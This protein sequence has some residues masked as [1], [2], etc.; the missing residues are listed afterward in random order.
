ME[1][2]SSINDRSWRSRRYDSSDEEE[3]EDRSRSYDSSDEAKEGLDKDEGKKEVDDKQ[4]SKK[5]IE[6]ARKKYLDEL[7]NKY[8]LFSSP[9]IKL[10][11]SDYIPYNVD[12]Y[13]KIFSDN[14][15]NIDPKS[16]MLAPIFK[17][18][19]LDLYEERTSGFYSDILIS[20]DSLSGNIFKILDKD[21]P[22]NNILAV[23][24]G[25]NNTGR[26]KFIKIFENDKFVLPSLLSYPGINK[27]IQLDDGLTSINMINSKPKFD[28]RKIYDLRNDIR[29]EINNAELDILN[30]YNNYIDYMLVCED[31]KCNVSKALLAKESPFFYK[32]FQ[33][34]EEYIGYPKIYIDIYQIFLL[35]SEIPEIAYPLISE[36]MI[37]ADYIMDY[38]FLSVIL[39]WIEYNPDLFE[40]DLDYNDKVDE[41]LTNILFP[42]SSNIKSRDEIIDKLD[43]M[44]KVTKN[45]NL[46]SQVYYNLKPFDLIVFCND[47]PIK[48]NKLI[49]SLNSPYF[50]KLLLNT[51]PILN[52]DKLYL[53]TYQ[54]YLFRVDIDEELIVKNI[55]K[56][57]D[58]SILIKDYNFLERIIRIMISD[59]KLN[60]YKK[61][62]IYNYILNIIK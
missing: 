61:E 8:K 56:F 32:L 20:Y 48:V 46:S 40:D 5:Q 39:E 15:K 16:D 51:K 62:K 26:P 1:R 19:F 28:L 27:S 47:G 35:T 50:Y 18:L 58:F 38:R 2:N 41:I 52:Y 33:K 37:F 21:D 23:Y 17:K 6:K 44:E 45:L 25:T 29:K 49:L 12:E 11:I 53:D 24:I 54:K 42:T 4:L 55:Y 7:Y 22:S 14:F 9:F 36:L 13:Y 31:E 10:Q 3:K 60:Y 59:S 57:I 34:Q 43:E 30:H